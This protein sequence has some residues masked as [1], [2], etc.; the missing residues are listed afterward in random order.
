MIFDAKVV[1]LPNHLELV[2][3]RLG[4]EDCAHETKKFERTRKALQSK[5]AKLSDDIAALFKKKAD[6]VTHIYFERFGLLGPLQQ[7]A[8]AR[9]GTT[10]A[11][12]QQENAWTSFL[13]TTLLGCNESLILP[14]DLAVPVEVDIED[15]EHTYPVCSAQRLDKEMELANKTLKIEKTFKLPN[16]PD[17]IDAR[18]K[19]TK[20]LEKDADLDEAFWAKFGLV[21]LRHLVRK[22]LEHK[23][24]V[25]LSVRA[26]EPVA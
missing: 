22:S 6:P 8:C 3:E 5:N 24:P 2:R 26:L 10:P 13:H 11:K 19:E 12:V 1:G 23:L 7:W 15:Q 4:K 14:M 25:V 21:V 18:R 17:F 20:K 9:D 16:I